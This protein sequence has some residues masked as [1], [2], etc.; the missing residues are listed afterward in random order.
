MLGYRLYKGAWIWQKG[1]QLEE[2]LNKRKSSY[3]LRQGGFFIRNTYNFDKQE[4]TSFWFIIKDSFNGLQDTPS[5]YR[6]RIRTA[7]ESF[8]YRLVDK[9][10]LLNNGYEVYVKAAK[11]YRI[12]TGVLTRDEFNKLIDVDCRDHD[13]WCCIHKKNGKLA[14]FAVNHI[15]DNTVDYQIMKFHPEYLSDLH[16]SYG[17]VYEM[18]RFYLGEKKMLFVSDGTRSITN[19][20]EIQPFLVK[21]FGFRKAY[22]NLQIIYKSW[23]RWVIK[24]LFPFRKFIK[25]RNLTAILLQ[26]A[27][28]RN[29][30]R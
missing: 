24:L 6:S 19:H 26:E 12:K 2:R 1:P 20:S 30:E 11:N 3:L 4:N 5:K 29:L 16:P 14:A 8:D 10:F 25:N 17:L 9:D 13:F 22:C 7:L 21:K 27:W 18:N 28:A 23:L 15:A